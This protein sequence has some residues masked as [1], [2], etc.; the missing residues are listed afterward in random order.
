MGYALAVVA[1]LVAACCFALAAVV[2]QGSAQGA[3]SEPLD[4]RLLLALLRKPRWLAGQALGALSWVIQAVALAFGPITLVLPL[5]AT[6]VVFALPMIAVAHRYRPTPR[7]WAGVVAVGAGIAVFLTV[8]PPTPG[9][10]VPPF[11]SWVPAMLG[12]IVLVGVAVTASTRTRGRAQTMW[13][14]AAAGVTFGMLDALT[15]SSVGLLTQLGVGMLSQ[16][17]LYA[18]IAAGLVGL[19]LSQSAFRA[20]A[21]SLS[22]PII[23]TVEPICAVTLGATIFGEQLASSLAHLLIQVAG[24]AVAV[25]GIA[26][27]SHSSVAAAETRA[28]NIGS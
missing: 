15:K 8:S 26:L 28:Q 1:A 6:D 23:D 20:G 24:G 21:L 16:W 17:E 18:A 11:T 3:S 4:P 7:D 25:F 13:L 10:R 2:Q 12:A 9:N 19:L 22:L 27:L 5:A 14:A